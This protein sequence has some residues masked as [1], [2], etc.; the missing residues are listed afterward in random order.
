M[1]ILTPEHEQMY[2]SILTF[3]IAGRASGD[4]YRLLLEDHHLRCR[5]VT[6]RGLNA[7][8]LSWHVYNSD[9]DIHR[10]AEAIRRLS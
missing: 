4:L 7:I 10:L 2:N 5:N 1:E 6:E 8:R 9:A 3:R